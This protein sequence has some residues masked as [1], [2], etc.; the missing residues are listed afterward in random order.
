MRAGGRT[1]DVY[2]ML[3]MLAAAATGRFLD[4][5]ALLPGVAEA[6][7]VRGG[8]TAWLTCLV[9]AACIGAAAS[10]RWTATRSI[11]STAR[12]V[13]PGQVVGFFAAEAAVRVS[14][15]LGPIDPDGIAGAL[16]QAGLAMVLLLA[17]TA[18]WAV[19]LRAAPLSV[20]VPDPPGDLRPTSPT[21]CPSSFAGLSVLARG[22]PR[23]AGT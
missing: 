16:L 23:A 3:A 17:V 15:G 8:G 22:P 11:R 20:G 7:K 1:S 10:A 2:L 4:A 12:L 21:T 18:A 5:A 13:V 19:A 14:N 6:A 9:S